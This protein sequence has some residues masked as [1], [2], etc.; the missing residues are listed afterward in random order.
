MTTANGDTLEGTYAGTQDFSLVDENG[1]GLS[2]ER[3]YGREAVAT[4]G[5][6]SEP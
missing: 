5:A 3:H 4:D 2:G 1:F 6:V